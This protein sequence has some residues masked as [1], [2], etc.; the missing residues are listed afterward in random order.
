MKRQGNKMSN[1]QLVQFIEAIIIMLETT[2]D[3]N[4]VIEYL[5]R[6]QKKE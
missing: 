4:Q 3:V 2:N 1:K 6:I 5:K